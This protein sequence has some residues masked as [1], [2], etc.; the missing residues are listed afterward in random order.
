MTDGGSSTVAGRDQGPPLVREADGRY[1]REGVGGR[2]RTCCDQARFVRDGG[3]PGAFA[4]GVSVQ[5]SWRAGT[6]EVWSVALAAADGAA[7]WVDAAEV[8]PDDDGALADWLADRDRPK[9]MHDA[10]GPMLALAAR[11]WPLSI[12]A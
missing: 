7:A 8:T 2:R 4:P 6:G 3:A 9:V 10:K 5:G 11:G 1:G 12:A